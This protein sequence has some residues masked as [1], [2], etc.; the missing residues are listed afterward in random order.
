MA[1]S[2]RWDFQ[3]H[4]HDLHTR[5]KISADQLGSPL[6]NRVYDPT[7]GQTESLESFQQRISADFTALFADF[8]AHHLPRPQLFAYPFSEVGDSDT[9]SQAAAFSQRLIAGDFVASLTNK[10]REP[11]P[12]SRRS[13]AGGQVD[14]VEVYATTTAAELVGEVVEWTARQPSVTNA[15]AQPWDWRDQHQEPATTLAALTGGV[16]DPTSPTYAYAALRPYSSADWT[17]YTVTADVR[18]LRAGNMSATVAVRVD[19]DAA[20]SA[21]V[22]NSEV[23]LLVGTGVVAS[24]RIGAGTSHHLE[25]RV[26]GARPLYGWTAA[27][28]WVPPTRVAPGPPAASVSPS[29]TPPQA[30]GRPSAR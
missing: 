25:V 13:A 23:E 21:R 27:R 18:E 12:S 9:D 15:F 16:A 6:T 19:S 11:Q 26:T 28:G 3:A 1:A 22:S 2:G 5:V 20:V 8:T 17:D 10:S 24:A 29:T 4:T 30:P 14:R 7:T